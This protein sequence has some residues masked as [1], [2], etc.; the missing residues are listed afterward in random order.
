MKLR[1]RKTDAWRAIQRRGHEEMSKMKVST[2]IK[3]NANS[4]LLEGVIVGVREP[5]GLLSP[6]YKCKWDDGDESGWL[7]S[8][9]LTIL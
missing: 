6:K 2:R 7:S 3:L 8:T 5:V 1:R 9:E 4:F